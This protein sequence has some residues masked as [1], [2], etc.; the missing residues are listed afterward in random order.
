MILR[1]VIHQVII[2]IAM[3]SVDPKVIRYCSKIQLSMKELTFISIKS[4]CV[5]L[6]ISLSYFIVTYV[7]DDVRNH[8]KS[9]WNPN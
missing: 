9:N 4:D 5:S 6:H 1:R 3:L 8:F 2:N 7:F